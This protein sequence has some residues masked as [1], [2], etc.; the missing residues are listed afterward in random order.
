M[1]SVWQNGL[2]GL[3][4]STEL[5][6]NQTEIGPCKLKVFQTNHI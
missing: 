6:Q 1:K 5:H 4:S 3:D 2:I